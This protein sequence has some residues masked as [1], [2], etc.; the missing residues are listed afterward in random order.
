MADCWT[1][2][3]TC[4]V[5]GG[6]SLWDWWFARLH[7]RPPGGC[8]LPQPYLLV[9]VFWPLKVMRFQVR[10]CIEVWR[11]FMMQSLNRSL[12]FSH[13]CSCIAYVR[14]QKCDE[15]CNV[16]GYY[17]NMWNI[18]WEKWHVAD[19]IHIYII[20]VYNI[21]SNMHACLEWMN[22]TTKTNNRMH[23]C[24]RCMCTDT[25]YKCVFI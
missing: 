24:V 6:K 25:M 5:S 8:I 23:T 19:Y 7:V 13:Y 4:K 22:A 10:K 18:M 15:K 1:K 11:H 17:S 9:K 12:T 16:Q 3:A 2:V 14:V 21:D 20:Y